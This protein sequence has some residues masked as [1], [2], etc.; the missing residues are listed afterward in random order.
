M[1]DYD[2]Y[3]RHAAIRGGAWVG[4]SLAWKGLAGIKELANKPHMRW[5]PWLPD[6]AKPDDPT[7]GTWGVWRW[8]LQVLMADGVMG[9]LNTPPSDGRTSADMRLDMLAYMPLPIMELKDADGTIYSVKMTGYIEHP[10]EPYDSAHQNGGW[11][12]QVELARV[13]G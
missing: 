10:I 12:V 2:F 4:F 3:L 13:E 6:P 1:S 8:R 7:A 5:R 9:L 11:L